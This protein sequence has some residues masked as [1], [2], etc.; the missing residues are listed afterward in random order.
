MENLQYYSL[1]GSEYHQVLVNPRCHGIGPAGTGDFDSQ[2]HLALE[3]VW[4]NW[5]DFLEVVHPRVHFVELL[6]YLQIWNGGSDMRL[7][8]RD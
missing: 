4:G 2:E 8:P 5:Q 6:W 7:A 1:S 3:A